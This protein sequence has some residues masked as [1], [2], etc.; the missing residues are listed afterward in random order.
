MKILGIDPSPCRALQGVDKENIELFLW[1][2]AHCVT[3]GAKAPEQ[4]N[5]CSLYPRPKGRGKS[6]FKIPCSG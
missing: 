5:E 2:L 3:L 6:T 4:K 1:A